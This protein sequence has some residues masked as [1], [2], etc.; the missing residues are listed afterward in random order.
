[1]LQ[2]KK[3][4][5]QGQVQGVGFRPFIY[6]LAHE[7]MLS[8]FVLND[9]YGVIIEIQGESCKIEN[10]LSSLKIKLPPLAKITEQH[11]QDIPLIDA[12]NT[13]D[14]LESTGNNNENILISPDTAP[15][16]DCI[17]DIFDA[18][19]RRYLYP[20]TNC[21]NCGPRYTITKNLP[22]DRINTSMVCFALCEE[23]MSE[24]QN[25]KDRRFHAQPNACH[26]CG[27]QVYFQNHDKSIYAGK[28]EK[29]EKNNAF[30]LAVK[31]LQEGYILAV[32]GLGGFHLVCDATNEN[33]LQILR[34]RKNRQHKPFAVMVNELDFA[35]FPL[36]DYVHVS[37]EEQKLLL[38]K[39]RPIV[40]LEKKEAQNYFAPSISPNAT[41]IGIM[42]PA[43]PLHHIL[44][45]Y[46]NQSAWRN[47]A[48]VM[49]SAN[50][51]GNPLVLGNREALHEL[52][53]IADFFLLHNR[54]ILT[55]VDDSVLCHLPKTNET[56][57]FRR[58]RGY[59]P[60]PI[61]LPK[62]LP[63]THSVL[64]FGADLKNTITLT[65]NAQAFTSQHIGD[66]EKIKTADF[67]TETCEHLQKILH[68]KPT[69]IVHDLHPQFISTQ[70]AKQ[71]AK[72]KNIPT[73]ALQH[74]KAHIFSVLAENNFQGKTLGLALDGTGLGDDNTL[75]GAECF[76]I[77]TKN[78][79]CN[80][81]ATATAFPLLGG[82]VAIKE[83]WRIAEA[84]L[85]LH[86][87]Q[88]PTHLRPWFQKQ[89]NL[90]P[91]FSQ[92]LK[93]NINTIYSSSC[94][95]L[96]DLVS[97]L[98]GL[99]LKISYEAQAAILLENIQN[100]SDSKEFY[101]AQIVYSKN[102]YIV[103]TEQ[104]ILQILTDIQ[105]NIAPETISKKFHNSL[106]ISYTELIKILAEKTD[107]KNIALSGGCLQNKTLA[108]ALPLRLKEAGLNVLTHKQLPPNDACISL[109]QAYYA[110]LQ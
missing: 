97:A 36:N 80:R 24:Y 15:C 105:S 32:K 101:S 63:Q 9:T 39:E 23:C 56:L 58:A 55:R 1:M 93:K 70:K 99:T 72:E 109:G 26:T 89:K 68:T 25:P 86:A 85:A 60:A 2:R 28:A 31:K 100:K 102:M 76:L 49:T 53:H 47:P 27:P 108:Q 71:F 75:W 35:P 107:C 74:H 4:S 3:I 30:K 29:A 73:L 51:S 18:E 81:L 67:Q 10:F 82:D 92:A 42:F 8:G 22:Y 41:N 78:S 69:L 6:T 103:Q 88:F 96:F 14:I 57:F 44:F 17:S 20:F 52:E 62:D 83:P 33:T 104:I 59:V 54:D 46:I 50:T 7:L 94:G 95:R 110:L 45:H 91:V 5:V 21:T 34:Q 37:N 79:L 19:N 64:A 66:L 77:D 98:L 16:E 87:P 43:T 40:L 84:F 65:K 106:I 13:F 61:F 12:E 38:S 90:L 11:C 48:L